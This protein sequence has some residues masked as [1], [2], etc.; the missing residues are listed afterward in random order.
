MKYLISDIHG[1]LMGFKN[2]LRKINYNFDYDELII[3]GDIFDRNR[4]GLSIYR[5]IKPF[6]EDGQMKMIIGNHELFAMMY[7]EGK[8]TEEKWISYGGEHTVKE[9]KTMS[10]E[11]QNELLAFLKQL[12]LYYEI[13]S[14]AYGASVVTHSGLCLGSYVYN[15][16]QTINV[17]RSIER[18]AKED[19]FEYLISVDLHYLSEQVKASLDKYLFVGHVCTFGLHEDASSRIY[20]SKHYM[21]LDCGAGYKELGG[22]LGCYCVDT[23]EEYYV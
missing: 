18:A 14:P 20:R 7:L 5:F 4:H 11:D 16:N 13:D 3:M 8:L 17:V 23:D 6:I 2:M 15:D 1:D 9:L 22:L 12:P 21:N 10:K 19:L